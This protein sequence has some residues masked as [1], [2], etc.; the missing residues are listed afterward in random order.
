MQAYRFAVFFAIV[1]LLGG[2]IDDT[3]AMKDS[4]D[5]FPGTNNITPTS[6]SN[7]NVI[8]AE[9]IESLDVDESSSTAIGAVAQEYTVL[10]LGIKVF[11]W[12][13]DIS[14]TIEYAMY[15]DVTVPDKP[16]ENESQKTKAHREMKEVFF[17]ISV[18]VDVIYIIAAIQIWR[19][20]PLAGAH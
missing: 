12:I 7:D 8:T 19:K 5:W 10:R 9:E 13:F 6:H 4:K 18:I 14:D 15:G 20:T 11:K 2:I 3:M 1:G 16:S 17:M